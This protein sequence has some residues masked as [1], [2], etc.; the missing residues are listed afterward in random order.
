MDN[1]LFER[2]IYQF[3]PGAARAWLPW[4]GGGE[5][6]AQQQPEIKVIVM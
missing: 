5:L 6:A 2:K 3:W 4:G 1:T